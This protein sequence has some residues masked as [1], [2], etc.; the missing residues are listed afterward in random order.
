MKTYRQ[1]LDEVAALDSRSGR[2][3]PPPSKPAKPPF[4]GFDTT[5]LARSQNEATSFE[6]R[7]PWLDEIEKHGGE[8][9]TEPPKAPE[10]GREAPS[11]SFGSVSGA[12]SE[13]SQTYPCTA[14]GR[15]AY[16]VPTTCYWCR[17]RSDGGPIGEP[18]PGCGEA[19]EACLPDEGGMDRC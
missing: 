10:S 12:C 9:L 8:A 5:P 17:R 6:D 3:T 13:K 18:C 19:C 1:L 4:D 11:V 14:C 16:H 2:A 7:R 15:H